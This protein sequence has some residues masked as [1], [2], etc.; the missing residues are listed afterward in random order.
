MATAVD[1]PTAGVGRR[2]KTSPVQTSLGDA[3]SNSRWGFARSTTPVKEILSTSTITTT[4]ASVPKGSRLERRRSKLSLFNLFN[5]PRVEKQRGYSEPPE[6]AVVPEVERCVAQADATLS[7]AA[8]SRTASTAPEC[9]SRSGA[10]PQNTQS[11]KEPAAKLVRQLSD[12][13]PPP[14]FQAYP[15][16]T[17]HATVIASSSSAEEL[18]RVQHQKR[19]L[20]VLQGNLE[21]ILDLR[22]TPRDVDVDVAVAGNSRSNGKRISAASTSDTVFL[23]EKIFVLVTAGYVLQYAGDGPSD[24]L[25]EKMLQLGETS[26]AFACDLIPGKH[27]VVQISQAADNEG[28]TTPKQYKS[29]LSMLR[30]PASRKL[31]TS[32]LLVLDSADEMDS[33]LKAVRRMIGSLGGESVGPESGLEEKT[34]EPVEEERRLRERPSHRYLVQRDPNFDRETPVNWPLD[35]PTVVGSDFGESSTKTQANASDA[36]SVS[37]SRRASVR[38]SLEASSFAASI[39]SNDQ[40]R[41]DHLREN[42]RQSFMSSKTSATTMTTPTSRGSSPIPPS[43]NSDMFSKA[44]LDPLRNPATLKSSYMNPNALVSNRRRSVQ[45]LPTTREN[46]SLLYENRRPSLPMRNSSAGVLGASRQ[47][48]G[49]SASLPNSGNRYPL[50]HNRTWPVQSTL[51]AI[52]GLN[53]IAVNNHLPSTSIPESPTN[54]VHPLST[55]GRLPNVSNPSVDSPEHP[56]KPAFRPLPIR[57]ASTDTPIQRRTS[58]LSN[59]TPEVTIPDSKLD[60]DFAAVGAARAAGSLMPTHGTPVSSPP[61]SPPTPPIPARSA[62]RPPPLPPHLPKSLRRPSGMQIR[63]DPAPFLSSARPAASSSRPGAAT[64]TFAQAPS[65]VR[66]ASGA[67]GGADGPHRRAVRPRP[68]PLARTSLAPS[69]RARLPPPSTPP[70]EGPLPLP[71]PSFLT[72]GMAV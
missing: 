5:R 35:S 12:W 28:V 70:P 4:V 14:L 68:T 64:P 15:Q 29:F 63:A 13:D 26:A 10:S 47:L 71:P 30:T 49:M 55:L 27:W 61:A 7:N 65:G 48:E 16:S 34:D 46:P 43:P 60:I 51:H 42:S 21:D 2:N 36:G 67:P 25:P 20:S 3:F 11:Q 32:F 17:K 37:S 1:I 19:Q 40:V 33:W 23:H 72:V 9:R 53:G 45:T 66:P 58:P 69:L 56:R 44:D 18:L 24:R 39:I 6:R 22:V 8:P 59:L 52:T 62:A 54:T 57:V 31:T 41:L 38:Q 50:S